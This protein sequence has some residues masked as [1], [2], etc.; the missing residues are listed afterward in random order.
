M[1]YISELI[2][3][4]SDIWHWT[5]QH[6]WFKLAEVLRCLFLPGVLHSY[7]IVGVFTLHNITG[8]RGCS[9]AKNH[10]QAVAR[11]RH[12]CSGECLNPIFADGNLL[13]HLPLDLSRRM[14]HSLCQV[15]IIYLSWA[16]WIECWMETKLTDLV[17]RACGKKLSVGWLLPRHRW[18]KVL[19][20]CQ[21]LSYWLQVNNAGLG[22]DNASL[23]DG[24]TSAWVEMISTNVLGLCMCTREAITVSPVFC[25]SHKDNKTVQLYD[26][27][28]MPIPTSHN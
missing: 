22:R 3:K 2:N 13:Y 23:F 5:L 26:R 28:H 1:L 15:V 8:S 27:T 19:T 20:S 11:C 17:L 12:W 16:S 21:S 14:P 6:A 18:P 7:L 9:F 10:C 25:L 4:L 24:K